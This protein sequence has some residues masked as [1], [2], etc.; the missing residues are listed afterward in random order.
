M[1]RVDFTDRAAL[2]S[3]QPVNDA[4]MGGVSAGALVAVP[5]GA[6]FTGHVSLAHGGGFA[7]VRSGPRA[8]PTAGARALR[9]TARG[10]GR[11]C[12][13]TLRTDDRCDGIRYQAAFQPAADWQQ[14]VLPLA[15]LRGRP[16]PGA[17]ALEAARIRTLGLLIAARQQGPFCLEI[18]RLAAC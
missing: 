7:S 13:L 11:R 1:L 15:D 14:V 10:D 18:A 8:G 12:Q 6:A 4:V 3:W 16:Q 5:G 2:A 17:A 9:V